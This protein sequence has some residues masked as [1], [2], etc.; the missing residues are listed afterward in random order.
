[1]QSR[2]TT[3]TTTSRGWSGSWR[4]IEGERL[5]ARQAWILLFGITLAHELTA[6]PGELLSEEVDRQLIAHR[7]ATIGFGAVTVAHLY[8]LLPE[9]VDPYH[10]ASRLVRYISE[11]WS[12]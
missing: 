2:R 9:P 7:W 5:T 10:Q 4:S 12:L 11:R 8:N 3:F 1:M 6:R